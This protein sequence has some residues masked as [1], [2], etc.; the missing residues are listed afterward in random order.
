[1]LVGFPQSGQQLFLFSFEGEVFVLE[2]VELPSE[3]MV[4]SEG[5]LEFVTIFL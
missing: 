1:V 2:E 5:L 3:F 4:G